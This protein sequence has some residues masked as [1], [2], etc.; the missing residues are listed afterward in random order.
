MSRRERSQPSVASVTRD[1]ARL[2]RAEQVELLAVLQGLL[3]AEE[4][5]EEARSPSSKPF[6]YRGPKGGKGSIELKTING[7]GPYR[8]LRYWSGNKH[9]SVYLGKAEDAEDCD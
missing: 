7:C 9:R 8:Y 2:T 4:A 3:A 6:T 5:Q 1:L